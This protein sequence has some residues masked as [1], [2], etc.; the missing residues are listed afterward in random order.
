ML[1]DI[2]RDEG[3]AIRQFVEFLNHPLGLD[4]LVVVL[5]SEALKPTPLVDLLPPDL[6]RCLV[7]SL[8]AVLDQL[9]HVPEH[10][11]HR[12]DD[13]DLHRNVLGN[14]RRVDVDMD[15]AGMRAEFGQISRYPVIKTRANGNQHIALMHRH[16]GFIGTVHTQHADKQRVSGRKRSESHQGIGAGITQQAHKLGE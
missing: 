7:G 10:D 11:V 9:D 8:L 1:A 2:G 15:D 6:K 5:V 4:H 3:V 12:S 13:G 14:R 16:V